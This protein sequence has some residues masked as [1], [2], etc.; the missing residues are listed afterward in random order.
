[1]DNFKV[2][3]YKVK[4][5]EEN[6]KTK[7]EKS[8]EAPYTLEHG[9]EKEE[10]IDNNGKQNKVTYLL[11]DVSFHKEVYRPGEVEFVVQITLTSASKDFSLKNLDDK[12]GIKNRPIVDLY[13][14]D[15]TIALTYWVFQTTFRK[16]HSSENQT[17]NNVTEYNTIYYA[18]FK[19]YSID[20]FLTID[21]F[22][23]AFTGRKLLGDVYYL[24]NLDNKKNDNDQN[25]NK[26]ND[27]DQSKAGI[28]HAVLDNV[29][30]TAFDR[31]KD[32]IDG[33]KKNGIVDKLN[34][35]KKEQLE[36]VLPYNVQYNESFY[37]FLVRICNRN[38]EFL[39]CKN[40]QLFVGLDIASESKE[41]S[42]YSG[43]EYDETYLNLM[44][45]ADW[46]DR[47]PLVDE[48]TIPTGAAVMTDTVYPPDY[49]ATIK[50][51]D[52][53]AWEDYVA[54]P[55]TVFTALKSA[56]E[57][58]AVADIIATAAIE[59]GMPNAYAAVR[60]YLIDKGYEN[61][62]FPDDIDDYQPF[63]NANIN[64]DTEFY[65]NILEGEKRSEQGRVVVTYDVCQIFDLG[66][67]VKLD[68]SEY[69]VYRVKGS[70]KPDG[71]NGLIQTYELLLVP[72][73]KKTSPSNSD[74]NGGTSSNSGGNGEAS[75]NSEGN[76]GTS[77]NSGGNGE[78]SSNSEGNGGTSSNS[79]GNGEASSNSEG[80]GGTSSNSGGNGEASSNSNGNGETSSNSGGNGEASSNSEGNGGTSSNS[81]GNGETSSTSGQE[82]V[83]PLPLTDLRV[84]KSSPQRAIVVSNYDPE[85]LGRVRVRYFWQK[86]DDDATP[87]IRVSAPG[88]SKGA[89]LM[90][91]HQKDDEVLIDYDEGNIEHP[92]VAGA[93]YNRKNELPGSS[94]PHLH[95]ESHSLS[96]ANG[97]HLS[98]TDTKSAKF[99]AELVPIWSTLSKFGFGADFSL[100]KTEGM[101]GGFEIAD[102][103]G[104]YSITGSTH[105]RNI[106]INSPLGD[107]VLDA[108]TGISIK[109][110]LGN[111]E[112][113]GKNVRIEARNNLE[114]ISGSNI[115]NPYFFEGGWSN[116]TATWKNIGKVQVKALASSIGNGMLDFLGV[117]LA[118]YRTLLEVFLRPIGGTMLIK[119]NRFMRLEAGEGKASI[120]RTRKQSKASTAGHFFTKTPIESVSLH[121][122]V[123]K[124]KNA[125]KEY[126]ELYDMVKDG[127]DLIVTVKA[128]HNEKGSSANYTKTA[129]E[130]DFVEDMFDSKIEE[131]DVDLFTQGK[132]LSSKAIN[133]LKA[134]L[135]RINALKVKMKSFAK[136]ED[137]KEWNTYKT[138]GLSDKVRN[139][140]TDYL[141]KT[142]PN[143]PFVY[144]PRAIPEKI[145]VVA[146]RKILVDN[147]MDLM[148][149]LKCFENVEIDKSKFTELYTT[150]QIEGWELFDEMVL[151]EA[152]TN[153]EESEGKK[154]VLQWLKEFS[155]FD[156]FVDDN[157]WGA[158]DKGD[159]I[160]SSKKDASYRIKD[161]GGI[162]KINN[163]I[164]EELIAKL[165][166][167]KT[168]N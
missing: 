91:Y 69:I 17:V 90:F 51:K 150:Q 96:S 16:G 25:D 22:N 147:V 31:Y 82:E 7:K 156:G 168:F 84:R 154:K 124:V 86:K 159:I 57:C 118:L 137:L 122:L 130:I 29:K 166:D 78:A 60:K 115:K 163:D 14:G 100:E 165:I 41:L 47:N 161:D 72:V 125:C 81:G 95:G 83:Y 80:N 26:Q 114:L 66:D 157:A 104:F 107:I 110:P 111:I 5:T 151:K 23:S 162:D 98:F 33:T 160:F 139:A 116:T 20:K 89:G 11:K 15:S 50:K 92:F 112:L 54:W 135:Q 1:M 93:L 56:A 75:S 40:N 46:M 77:S 36:A 146:Y 102:K 113:V 109:A 155:K 10:N 149:K 39:Y 123:T 133:E 148:K 143:T 34:Y 64:V 141:K 48:Y 55:S 71:E 153:K 13:L 18:T 119:S 65:K 43:V 101:G 59:I 108:F 28:V 129:E 8:T 158:D 42:G 134:L 35:L 167:A 152:I 58:Q 30:T 138:D 88:A 164:K 45:E 67:K 38:G 131:N 85:K 103:H 19:A 9:T 145:N 106:S 68:G 142:N 12:K 140:I 126:N 120:F 76:G 105:G 63:T 24:N 128:Y 99:G 144:P 97:H 27:N 70:Y 32:C 117:D 53:S 3:F 62:Y 52:Y 21:K 4:T 73:Q 79:G 37:H 132:T 87:W 6:G 74:G 2:L 136:Y 94:E 121:E 49:L 127:S 44:D 61:E